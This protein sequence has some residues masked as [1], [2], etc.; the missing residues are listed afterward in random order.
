[1]ECDARQ[2]AGGRMNFKPEDL[3][4]AARPRGKRT[5]MQAGVAFVLALLTLLLKVFLPSQGGDRKP[6]GGTA[7]TSGTRVGK[8]D[9][10]SIVN[11]IK[12]QA[13]GTIVEGSGRVI[14][15]LPDDNDESRHQRFLIK[16]AS[17]DV[18]KIS[19]NID[20]AKRLPIE[21]KDTVEFYGQFEWNDLGAA[22]HWTHRDLRG[23]HEDGWL[24]HRGK[25]YQ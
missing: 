4:R 16:L 21:V 3:I 8:T 18:V 14:K 1:M 24:K 23:K 5:A 25:T 7:S 9:D 12:N 20:V 11:A 22:V 19:H 6:S 10:L 13:S 2:R 17:G 15:V